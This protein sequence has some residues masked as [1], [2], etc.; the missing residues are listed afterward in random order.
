MG[1]G[2]AAG[3]TLLPVPGPTP[4]QDT[5]CT[6]PSPPPCP[7]HPLPGGPAPGAAAS[8]W[9][10]GSLGPP[11]ATAFLQACG[12][13]HVGSAGGR[14]GRGLTLSSPSLSLSHC[15]GEREGV[16]QPH[17]TPHAGRAGIGRHWGRGKECG[18][19]GLG[20]GCPR[21]HRAPRV[22]APSKPGVCGAG[23]A[24]ARP[25]GTARRQVRRP[26]A[27]AAGKPR[28]PPRSGP[29]SGRQGRG[30]AGGQGPWGRRGL[31]QRGPAGRAPGVPAPH[32][33]HAEQ[34]SVS[35]SVLLGLRQATNG[36]WCCIFSRQRF[37]K[38][39]C[40][41][42][43]DPAREDTRAPPGSHGWRGRATAPPGTRACRA[44][45]RAAVPGQ[46]A[47]SPAAEGRVDHLLATEPC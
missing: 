34:K 11:R 32:A 20:W 13:T 33:P 41:T 35:M 29:A 27:D 38:G 2:S 36:P 10:P 1:G 31:G 24:E 28:A 3:G 4:A 18:R 22:G 8:P 23:K 16:S 14:R 5:G 40:W 44:H 7:R 39:G 26:K 30:E 6:Q 46:R 12:C 9:V 25:R 21:P 45:G 19:L 15:G 17:S 43:T 42:P 47:L 37:R